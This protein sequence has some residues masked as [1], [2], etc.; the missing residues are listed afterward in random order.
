M[1]L[2]LA[3]IR[4]LW[5]RFEGLSSRFDEVAVLHEQAGARLD[6]IA[7]A[8]EAVAGRGSAAEFEAF[9]GVVEGVG[10]GLEA[11]VAERDR[12][13]TGQF[14]RL[15]ARLD[16]VV[17]GR[18]GELVSRIEGL[19]SR[20]DE[21]A[22]LHEQTGSRFEASAAGRNREFTGLFERLSAQV[23]ELV[24]AGQ[25]E[26]LVERIA[27]LVEAQGLGEEVLGRLVSEVAAL[28]EQNEVILE[29]VATGRP[30]RPSSFQTRRTGVT[31]RRRSREQEQEEVE[32]EVTR[33]I[34]QRRSARV[35]LLVRWEDGTHGAGRLSLHR[36][37][38]PD[39]EVSVRAN[40][41]G[42]PEPR[43]QFVEPAWP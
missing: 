37:H 36:F 21:L 16:E 14:E 3:A 1:S 11:S 7:A 9:A 29:A 32:V 20:F 6:A 8:Q 33:G 13:L 12:E 5:S 25:A 26:E 17:D 35:R 31:R 38:A 19:S 30:R 23:G 43:P 22:A 18:D 40:R 10:A 42:E 15:S 39:D 27:S 34:S 24:A 4:S 2:W 28:H 41:P